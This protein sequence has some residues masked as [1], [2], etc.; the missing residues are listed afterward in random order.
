MKTNLWKEYLYFSRKERMALVILFAVIGLLFF[1][2]RFFTLQTP[3]PQIDL[4][5]TAT[6]LPAASTA[7]TSS[8][9]VTTQEHRLFRFD[10]NTL[11]EEGLL[12]LGLR[13]RVVRT[14]IH[15]R[16]KGGH[17]YKPEDLRKIYGLQQTEADR[18]IP[19]IRIPG[20]EAQEQRS[21]QRMETPPAS[22]Q[23][24]AATA[25]VTHSGKQFVVT[26]INQAT[27]EDWMRFP[28]IGEVLS[29]RIVAFRH[30]I[31][32]FQ[33]VLQVKQTYGLPDTV[34]ERML[35]YLRVDTAL[36]R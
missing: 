21:G 3:P 28:G 16:S 35:P 22:L 26:D 11:N 7:V 1:I 5:A 19:Y 13:E 32:G 8:T 34:F 9:T 18:L 23:Q 4:A 12:Q 27:A 10:P 24:S 14:L 15:Y 31:G 2:P 17:F 25:P 36:R 6:Y 30:K 29:R 20:R 33:T